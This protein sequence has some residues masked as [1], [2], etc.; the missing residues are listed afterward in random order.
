M[1][2][3]GGACVEHVVRM[4]YR[5][6]VPMVLLQVAAGATWLAP[7]PTNPALNERLCRVS[8]HARHPLASC[9]RGRHLDLPLSRRPP[10]PPLHGLR[11]QPRALFR[12]R[13]LH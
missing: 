13:A 12:S 11:V 7:S 2:V 3:W 1:R 10:L 9:I 6:V 5:A 8:A 4:D